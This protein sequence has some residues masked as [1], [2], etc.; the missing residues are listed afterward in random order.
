METCD[1]IRVALSLVYSRYYIHTP[2]LYYWGLPIENVSHQLAHVPYR[3]YTAILLP[4]RRRCVSL[5]MRTSRTCHMCSSNI[6]FLFLRVIFVCTVLFNIPFTFKLLSCISHYT[7]LFH[8]MNC[9]NGVF[10]F[11][12]L[13]LGTPAMSLC[14]HVTWR[15]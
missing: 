12:P 10:E 5:R 15:C 13:I 7:T 9:L 1:D 6:V 14:H 4:R 3:R 8:P 11:A 2:S